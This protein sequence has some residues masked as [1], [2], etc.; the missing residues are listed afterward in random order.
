MGIMLPVLILGGTGLLMGLFLAFASKKFEVAVDPKVEQVLGVLPG[1]NCGACGYPGCSGYAEAIALNGAEITACSPGGAAVAQKIADIMGMTADLSGDKIVA[2]VLCQGDNTR[3]NK[4]YEF[5]GELVSCGAVSLYAGGDKSCQYSCLGYG[6]CAKVC[7]VNAITI[8][9]KGIAVIDEEKCVSCKKCV[10]TCPKKVIDMVPQKKKVTVLCSS[11]EKG[12]AARK[13]CTVACIACG[14]CQRACPVDAITVTNNLAK[15][16][17]D[18]CI[19]CNQCYVKCPTKAIESETKV[20][21]KAEIIPEKCIGCTACARVCPVTAIEG[22]VK[23]KHVVIE[24]KC[25]GCQLCFD[26]CKFGAIKMNT[27]EINK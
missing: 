15:I 14:M 18:K 23:Q 6:D 13:N 10:N 7:P 3:T 12:P 5:E 19:Q 22:A 8:T 16:D 25:V 11:R 20:I 21:R 9:E 24:E 27:Q 2:R 4:I 26:K 17:Y 1:I